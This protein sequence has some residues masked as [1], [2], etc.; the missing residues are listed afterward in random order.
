MTEA[1]KFAKV[2]RAAADGLS[3]MEFPANEP[4]VMAFATVYPTAEERALSK[5]FAGVA[6]MFE[7]IV[8][9]ERG[10]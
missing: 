8:E 5:A 7:K 3:R 10:L 2:F 4:G 6:S 1:E 9:A